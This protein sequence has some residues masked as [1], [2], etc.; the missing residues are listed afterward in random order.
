MNFMNTKGRRVSKDIAYAEI[1][2]RIISGE[3]APN[4]NLIEE[5]FANELEIS[6]TPLRE[7]LQRLETEDLLVR[8]PNGRLKVAPISKQ[9]VREIFTVRSMLEGLVARDAARLATPA[10]IKS[11]EKILGQIR[12]A[13]D[14]EDEE[15]I[16]QYGSEFHAQLYVISRNHTV[17]KILAMLN[18]RIYRYRRLIPKHDRLKEGKTASE[19]EFILKCITEKDEPAAEQAMQQHVLSSMEE[20][21]KGIEKYESS[22]TASQ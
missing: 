9:E 14:K 10:D 18:D 4:Q 12:L 3:L 15:E 1:K 7:A 5:N 13:M 6:R 8:Q 11:L 20:A 17:V 21:I 16:L 22:Q 19:H 2:Q